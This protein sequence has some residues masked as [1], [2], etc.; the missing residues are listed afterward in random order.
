M[1]AGSNSV[2]SEKD[3]QK[4]FAHM[5]GQI[6]TAEIAKREASA[7]QSSVK[8]LAKSYDPTFTAQK[9][10][11]FL[12]V[13][14]GE[15]DQK[16]VDRLRSDRENLE[17]AGL[18]TRTS[19]G[20]LLAQIDRVDGDQIIQ[21]KGYLAGLLKAPRVSGYD[22]GSA[23][24]KLFLESYDAGRKEVET[25]IPDILSRVEARNSKEEPPHTGDDPFANQDTMH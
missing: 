13:H 22:A 25:D 10:D 7:T 8:K 5:F 20:D 3:R 9:F 21:G 6:L 14:F 12:K 15:D 2:L 1:T 18:I 23:D 17:W 19:K 11:H 4:L 24:D 16:P